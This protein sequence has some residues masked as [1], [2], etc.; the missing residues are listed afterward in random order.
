MTPLLRTLHPTGDSHFFSADLAIRGRM[1]DRSGWQHPPGSDLVG[2][3]TTA[4]ES[5]VVYLQPGDGPTAY[6]DANY[7]TLLRNAIVWTAGRT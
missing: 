3:A 4:R 6:A 1:N 5:R 7:R 2:W